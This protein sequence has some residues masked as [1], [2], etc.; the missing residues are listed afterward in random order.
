M[1]SPNLLF[2][3]SDQHNQKVMG[4]MEHPHVHTPHLDALAREGTVFTAAYTPCPICVP[5]RAALATGRYVHQ[6]RAW[7]NAS[8]Y[9]GEQESW[10]HRLRQAGITVDSI[11]KLHFRTDKDDNGFRQEI[12]PLHI[13]DGQGD[14]LSCIRQDPP[15][16]D[17]RPGIL[18]AGSGNS[19]Y[20]DYDRRNTASALRWLREHKDDDR[21]WVL[22]L[23]YVCPHP[24]Y[25]S[26]P[27]DFGLYSADSLELPP[28]ALGDER[29]DHPVLAYFRRFF[30]LEEDLGEAAMRRMM[31]AYFG[32]CTFLDR[33]IGLVLQTLDELD[34]THST[35]VI[36][37]SDHGESHGARGLYGKFT[38]YDESCAVPFLMRGPEIPLNQTIDTPISLL[39]CYP[40]ILDST[41][42]LAAG[43]DEGLPGMSLL[44]LLQSPAA[45]RTVFSEYHAAGSQDGHYM[46]RNQQYKY[47]YFVGQEPMLFDMKQDPQECRNLAAEPSMT[48]VVKGFETELRTI[49]DPEQINR[50]AHQDQAERVAMAGGRAAV[51]ARGAFANSPV[52]GEEPMFRVYK[53]NASR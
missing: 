39:D 8:P 4:C 14:L 37:T 20:L 26:P 3:L 42:L 29:P 49:L 36:Y 32:A 17:Q 40:T 48:H 10:H 34:L 44:E 2:I 12:E 28:Q 7:D 21:P 15:F 43:S 6:L 25:I 45:D 52:P 50:Q 51:I 31:A 33:Q 23:S 18:R 30:S 5:A 19:T 27:E 24:P 46:L 13:V 9:R 22:F 11:G 16:R 38:L 35:R 53:D 1:P 47:M 41:N